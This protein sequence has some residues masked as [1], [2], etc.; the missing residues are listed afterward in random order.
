MVSIPQRDTS[1]CHSSGETITT[2]ELV[3]FLEVL[4]SR[5][6]T[7][8][9]LNLKPWWFSG[10]PWNKETTAANWK[11]EDSLVVS[12]H[13]KNMLVQLD[14]LPRDRGKNIKHEWN[15][16]LE[17]YHLAIPCKTAILF[18]RVSFSFQLP[19]IA[20]L[21]EYVGRIPQSA[22]IKVKCQPSYPSYFC[23]FLG[24]GPQ[25]PMSIPLKKQRAPLET[26]FR[27]WKLMVHQT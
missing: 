18:R 5:R 3:I 25:L 24:A 16:H 20:H 26:S 22:L 19:P 15:R 6:I 9:T 2:K 8:P 12:T 14:H 4:S 13:L 27:L 1:T 23:P 17:D 21:R 7:P 10:A 11:M